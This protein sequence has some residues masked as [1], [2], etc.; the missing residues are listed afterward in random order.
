MGD[1]AT[2]LP[3]GTAPEGGYTQGPTPPTKSVS[4]LSRGTAFYS[5]PLPRRPAPTLGWLEAVSPADSQSERPQPRR[6]RPSAHFP[7]VTA[8]AMPTAAYICLLPFPIFL[9]KPL[10]VFYVS[11]K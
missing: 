9:L 11:H 1:R 6:R 4:S 8:A 3:W 10:S 7:P 2:S 5:H